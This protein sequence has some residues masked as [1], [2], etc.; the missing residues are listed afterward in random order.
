[1]TASL[2]RLT[3]CL[4][5]A[6]APA[7]GTATYL[8]STPPDFPQPFNHDK[9][10]T[11]ITFAPRLRL[12]VLSAMDAGNDG[13]VANVIYEARRSR[14]EWSPP[15]RVRAFGEHAG[16]EVA[17][18][19]DGRWLYFSSDR[20]PGAP[21]RPRAFRAPVKRGVIGAPVAMELAIGP[22]AGVYYPRTLP[23]GDLLFTSRGP[24]G[25]DDLFIARARGGGFDQ[26]ELLGGDFNSSKDDWD[27]IE[28][29]DGR[30]RIWVSARAGGLGRTDLY[31]SRRDPSGHWSAARNLARANTPQLET[32]P[33][34]TPDGRALFFLR[35]VDGADRMFWVRLASV[36]EE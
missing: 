24:Q 9:A 34:L 11:S 31:F 35:R 29:P 32:A 25:A 19:P 6:A 28:S 15:V 13:R 16:G 14:D 5:V 4:F 36:L 33:A 30:L 27:L 1:M 17:F 18:S 12:A 2:I 26:P 8:G 7:A 22:E 23:N 10:L 3:L 20:P 21:G